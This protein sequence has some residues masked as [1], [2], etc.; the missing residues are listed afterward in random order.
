VKIKYLVPKLETLASYRIR[1]LPQLEAIQADGGFEI[2]EDNP[3]IFFTSKHF[4]PQ[5]QLNMLKEHNSV[6]DI[7][8]NH[9]E[10]K[11]LGDY[12]KHAV[13]L[14]N[15]VTCNTMEMYKQVLKINPKANVTIIPD[16]ISMPQNPPNFGDKTTF[17]WFGHISNIDSILKYWNLPYNL[18]IITNDIGY[19][20][21]KV[22]IHSNI[23]LME[24]RPGLVEDVIKEVVAV[25]IPKSDNPAHKTKSPNRVVDS[26]ISGKWVISDNE[27]LRKE[28]S[29]FCW[30]GDM[31]EGVKQFIKKMNKP[32]DLI[33]KIKE[34]QQYCN[35]Q[36]GRDVIASKWK[37]FYLNVCKA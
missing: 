17:L 18:I 1:F 15:Y 24:W 26:I 4:S 5:L 32:D 20:T 8:D 10:T 13:T 31:K 36:Y 33:A 23:I 27:D 2:V 7:C 16:S 29:K 12:Y 21:S 22:P 9:F 3:D 14:S 6:F 37:E 11:G 28:F 19:I 34:G 35:T 30:I 25:L